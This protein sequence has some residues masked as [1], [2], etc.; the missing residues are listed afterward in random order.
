M[1]NARECEDDGMS[2]SVCRLAPKDQSAA[3]KLGAI[4]FGYIDRDMPASWSP[5]APGRRSWGVFDEEDVLVA[6]AVDR[7]QRQ[8]FG[9]RLVPTC[10]VAGVA[11]APEHRASGLGRAVLTQLLAGA[12]DR[13]AVISTLFAT[14]PWP[15]RRLGWEEVGALVYQALPASAL[16]GVSSPMNMRLRA[17]HEGD[18]PRLRGIYQATARTSTG[19]MER[20]GPLFDKNPTEFLAPFDG[21]TVAVNSAGEVEGYSAWKRGTGYDANS[22]VTIDDLVALTSDATRALLANAGSWASVAPTLLIRLPHPDPALTMMSSIRSTVRSRQP[23]ML[24]VVDAAG[25]VAARGW[26]TLIDGEVGLSLEDDVCAWNGGDYRLV[27]SGGQ[28]RLEPSSVHGARMT[29]R[30]FALWYAGAAGPEVLRRA[31][32]LTGGDLSDDEFLGTA[33]AGPT[34]SLLDYF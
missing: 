29:A 32:L 26:P 10:G 11:V 21:V 31:G 4:A 20:S 22:T 13:G 28:G 2:F 9:G 5:N 7:E 14:T 8:W 23:W 16:A 25:A 12:R 15:Y 30:G 1:V 6:K 3:W 17:A 18:V 19:M 33:T 34:P 27:L 24:R